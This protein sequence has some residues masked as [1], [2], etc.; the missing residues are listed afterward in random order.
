MGKS[1][2]KITNWKEYNQA[3]VNRGSLTFWMDDDAIANWYCDTPSGRRG[4]SN[5]FSDS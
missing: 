2:R 4:R 3:L 1:K 5:E